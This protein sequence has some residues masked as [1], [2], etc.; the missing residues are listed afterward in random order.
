MDEPAGGPAKSVEAYVTLDGS[1]VLELI[2]PERG[3]SP[4]LSVAE[5]VVEPGQSTRRHL[6]RRS[7]EVYYILEGKGTVT[8]GAKGYEVEPGSCLLLPAGSVHSVRCDGPE[9]LRILCLCAPPYT[10]DQTIFAD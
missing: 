10:H 7:D 1:R 5:A 2:R 8:L 6:H 3:G 9:A 4:N